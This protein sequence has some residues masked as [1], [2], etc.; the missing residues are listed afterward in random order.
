MAEY[1]KL[2][3]KLAEI[4]EFAEKGLTDLK[5]TGMTC[6]DEYWML[7]KGYPLF[8]AGNPG[9]G[10]TEFIFEV[11]INTSID[12][13]WKHFIYCGEGGNIE[14]IFN[15]LLHKYLENNYKYVSESQKVAAEYFISEHFIIVDHDKDFTIDEFYTLAE[16]CEKEL[17]IKFSTTLFDP[18]NDIKDEVEKFA[19]RDDKYLEYALKRVRIS[20]KKNNRI[21][22]LINHVAD[23]HPKTDRDSGRDYLPPALPTQ[24]ARGR[25][26][27]RRAFVMILVYRPYT[28]MKGTDGDLHA[29]NETHIIVQKFKPKGVGK[30]GKAVIFWDWKKNRY[31]WKDILGNSVY[32]G[33]K[34]VT[35]VAEDVKLPPNLN[36]HEEKKT[37]DESPF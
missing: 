35:P 23:I 13:G 2:E 33:G 16:K 4:K 11:M 36:F 15:E 5:S 3:N 14:H 10:K 32:H 37:V 21:D 19:G 34:V 1:Y 24:W 20:S 7:K 9:A 27:W 25:T 31:Y 28:F 30:L 29:E 12:Y 6:I 17:G 22:I 26:W 18:F 8:V